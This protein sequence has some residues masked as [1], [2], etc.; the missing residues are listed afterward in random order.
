M[1]AERERQS[2]P[3]SPPGEDGAG[4]PDSPKA[5]LPGPVCR[6]LGRQALSSPSLCITPTEPVLKT[7]LLSSLSRDVLGGKPAKWPG[8]GCVVI[9]NPS[10]TSHPSL[11]ASPRALPASGWRDAGSTSRAALRQRRDD[12]QGQVRGGVHRFLHLIQHTC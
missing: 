1:R 6:R 11:A 12:G 2:S 10:V 3:R 4:A 9:N 8:L 5:E 7:D